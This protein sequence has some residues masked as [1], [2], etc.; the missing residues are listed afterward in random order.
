[1]AERDTVTSAYERH[2]DE[3]EFTRRMHAAPVS[4]AV[5]AVIA[6]MIVGAL[7]GSDEMRTWAFNLP[8]WMPF[9]DYVF[10][11]AD[12]WHELMLSI[13]TADVFPAIRDAFREFQYL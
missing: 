1:M 2:L 4:G 10:L 12:A 13:G 5:W 9:R 3:L 6:G 8:L 7:V 11:A